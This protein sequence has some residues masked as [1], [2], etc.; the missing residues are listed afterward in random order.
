VYE[1]WRNYG[2]R[3]PAETNTNTS[4]DNAGTYAGTAGHDS[5]DRHDPACDYDRACDC[6]CDCAYELRWRQ[7][8]Q[9]HR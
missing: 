9:R 7:A 1:R 2:R 6:A 8:H 5:T 3:A 4:A